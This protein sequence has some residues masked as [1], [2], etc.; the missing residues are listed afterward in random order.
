M[1]SFVIPVLNEEANIGRCVRSIKAHM[2]AGEPYEILVVDNGSTD[3]SKAQAEAAGAR[4]LD[5]PATT[6]AAVR[7]TGVQASRGDL[8]VFVDGDCAV[9][10]AWGQNVRTVFDQVR[11]MQGFAAAGS[12]PIPPS[13]E[14]VFLWKYW[15][16]PLFQDAPTSHLGTAHLMC[17]RSIFE[18]L[19]GFDSS[20]ETNEDFDF[21]ARITRRQGALLVRPELVVEH[22]GYPRTLRSFFRRERWH[23]RGSTVS[24]RAI[25]QSKVAAM[26]IAYAAGALA[27]LVGIIALNSI[28]S[29]VGLLVVTA[30]LSASVIVK[31]RGSRL[32]AK[33]IAACIFALYY[34]AHATAIVDSATR[35]FPRP[36]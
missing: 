11:S 28:V 6:V 7:N 35:R 18:E 25:L 19:S 30:V 2:P 12:H 22:Y 34:T 1:I 8:L 36:K 17:R 20:L 31:F 10:A 29:L 27:V 16:V 26:S 21:C 23:G 33:F 3:E 32:K 14:D 9:T 4:V 13:G 15:F 24:L 5:S